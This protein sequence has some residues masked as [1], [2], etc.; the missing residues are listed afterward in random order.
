M[1]QE[2]FSLDLLRWQ[3]HVSKHSS[4]KLARYSRPITT[5]PL[6]AHFVRRPPVLCS[7]H[8][9]FEADYCR[10][11][12]DFHNL[13]LNNHTWYTTQVVSNWRFLGLEGEVNFSLHFCRPQGLPR[14]PRR[15]SRQSSSAK[16]SCNGCSYSYA[17]ICFTFE[18]EI[19][20]AV[21]S[22][23][24]ADPRKCMQ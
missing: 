14:W 11:K 20:D 22:C 8:S 6:P 4:S 13:K 1:P 23:C 12:K 24:A 21:I 19:I 5:V 7:D 10:L 2:A 17:V 15:R 3:Q 16:K 9:S 18:S